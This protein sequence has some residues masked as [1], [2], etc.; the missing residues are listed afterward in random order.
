MSPAMASTRSTA[1]FRLGRGVRLQL[2]VVGETVLAA[3]CPAIADTDNGNY[4]LTR[5]DRDQISN[6]PSHCMVFGN[7]AIPV[8]DDTRSAITTW[9]LAHDIAVREV[10]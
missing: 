5:C 8:D 3:V 9:L 1:R 6:V 4:S 7:T 10:G 2:T